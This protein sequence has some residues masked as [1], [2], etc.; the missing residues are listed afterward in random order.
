MIHIHTCDKGISCESI[1]IERDDQQPSDSEFRAETESN[2]EKSFA[3][4]RKVLNGNPGD[5]VLLRLLCSSSVTLSNVF[6]F[7]ETFDAIFDQLVS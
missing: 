1:Q 7:V 3:V 4:L 5:D 6:D 2:W